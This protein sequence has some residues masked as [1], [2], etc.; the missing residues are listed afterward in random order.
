MQDMKDQLLPLSPGHSLN[1]LSQQTI[2]HH[3]A[4]Q[5]TQLVWGK[6][7]HRTNLSGLIV[8]WRLLSVADDLADFAKV[9]HTCSEHL[10]ICADFHTVVHTTVL[11]ASPAS[12]VN[13]AS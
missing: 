5:C 11:K 2:Y 1:L 9:M 3:F 12:A 8:N 6:L 4:L 7:I 10:S 13:V